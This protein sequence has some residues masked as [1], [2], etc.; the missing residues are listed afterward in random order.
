MQQGVEN[1][2]V[3]LVEDNAVDVMGV[4]RAFSQSKLTNRIVVASDGRDALNKLRD[5]KSIARPYVI[6]LD[7]NM[8]RMGGVE[9]LKEARNDPEL[10]SSVIF[11][12]TTSSTAEDKARA[13]AH[14]IAGYIVKGKEEG[15]FI[16]TASLF[17]HYTKTV[18]LP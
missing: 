1:I 2:S 3:L 5:G 12:L 11:V 16:N 13:Y 14:S 9:F 7:L 4:K 17:D 6:L 15:S 8:P 18:D 10:R